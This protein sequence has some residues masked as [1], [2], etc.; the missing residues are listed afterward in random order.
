MHMIYVDSASLDQIGFDTAEGEL[1]VIFK[2]GN[3]YIY[4]GV[5]ED[6]W[7]QFKDAGSKGTFL[8]NEF[9]A[10]AYPCRKVS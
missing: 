2:N 8:N 1:H 4:S 7:T 6:M 5:S 3:H 10:K 9:K